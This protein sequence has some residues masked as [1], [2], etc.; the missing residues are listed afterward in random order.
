MIKG[1]FVCVNDS[2]KTYKHIFAMIFLFIFWEDGG[3]GGG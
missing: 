2:S 1:V 3:W